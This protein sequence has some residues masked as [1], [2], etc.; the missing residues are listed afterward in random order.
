MCFLGRKERNSKRDR[1]LDKMRDNCTWVDMPRFLFLP[2]LFW[3]LSSLTPLVLWMAI[4]M[5]SKYCHRDADLETREPLLSSLL[6][7]HPWTPHALTFSV[8]V[9]LVQLAYTSFLVFTTNLNARFVFFDA[10][11]LILW[12]SI[13]WFDY[14]HGAMHPKIM[15]HVHMASTWVSRISWIFL[16]WQA[17][18]LWTW[19]TETESCSWDLYPVNI[20]TW[21]FFA[22]KS[23]TLAIFTI[24]LI[25]QSRL[26]LASEYDAL[27]NDQRYK[28]PTSFS[29]FSMHFSKLV[30]FIWPRGKDSFRL[31][32]LMGLSFVMMVLGRFVN[33]LVPIQYKRVV[34]ALGGLPVNN[35]SAFFNMDNVDLLPWNEILIFVTLRFLAG[36]SG[37]LQSL[38]S[39]FWIP[40]GQYT[41]REI[42][43]QM[44]RHLHK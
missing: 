40:V 17:Y 44:L 13:R 12:V 42:S 4:K 3:A 26:L 18:H 30:P 32:A 34:D 5:N 27:P 10:L 2:S 24:S 33:L 8:F 1:A 9:S 43:I 21:I 15:K 14:R 28:P 23:L 37:L 20:F 25:P 11:A 35:V 22:L 41:T 6:P 38:Q 36:S 19:S 16:L 7:M 39:F 29:E 31:Q